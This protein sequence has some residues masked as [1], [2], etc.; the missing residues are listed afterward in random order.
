MPPSDC[1]AREISLMVAIKTTNKA[2]KGVGSRDRKGSR[3]R[4]WQKS[5]K[6]KEEESE[7]K[8]EKGVT[9]GGHL[10]CFK[11]EGVLV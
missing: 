10:F 7:R 3:R 2:K 11:T 1:R 4:S 9:V 5:G 8:R 6:K